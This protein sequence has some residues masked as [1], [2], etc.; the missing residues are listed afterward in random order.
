MLPSFIQDFRKDFDQFL[1]EDLEP[2]AFVRFHDGEYHVIEGLD[3]QSRSGWT[4][5]GGPTWIQYPLLDALAYTESNYYIGISSPCDH[6][7][8]AHSYRRR[9]AGRSEN[10]HLTFSSIFAHAN[11]ARFSQVSKRYEDA[12]VVG[13]TDRCDF[14]VPSN[15]VTSQWDVD[16]LIEQLQTIE[17]RPIFVSAGP[18]SNV[19]IH[20]YWTRQPPDRRVTIIDVGAAIDEKIHGKTTRD[21]HKKGTG[22]AHR[23]EWESWVPFQPL[24]ES[25]RLAA[26]R[27]HAFS[28]RFQQLQDDGFKD[29]IG[30]YRSPGITR[31]RKSDRCGTHIKDRRPPGPLNNRNVK[32]RNPPK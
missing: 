14:K 24:T 29:R 31:E 2:F 1:R 7:E 16:G 25:R 5:D 4:T 30:P 11:Y 17:G 10:N 19:I 21:Y 18:C 22:V 13:S 26:A 15:G 27:K 6:S 8:A 20:H 28:T 3:Y 9:L 12:V 32:N 23:C